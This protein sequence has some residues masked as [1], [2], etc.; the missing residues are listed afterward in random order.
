MPVDER[1]GDKR[2]VLDREAALGIQFAL[3]KRDSC[4]G[5]ADNSLECISRFAR[6]RSV[7]SPH[8]RWLQCLRTGS[9]LS[10][11]PE[12]TDGSRRVESEAD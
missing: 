12:L 7:N 9:S 10:N 5:F 4:A 3:K 6:G 8:P 1:G 11:L 2:E